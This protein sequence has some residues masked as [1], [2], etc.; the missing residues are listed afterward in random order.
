MCFVGVSGLTKN[1]FNQASVS[2]SNCPWP[3]PVPTTEAAEEPPPGRPNETIPD[4][5]EL[6][7]GL[8]EAPVAALPTTVLEPLMRKTGA[9]VP[10][11]MVS[12]ARLPLPPVA[13]ASDCGGRNLAL[14]LLSFSAF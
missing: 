3:S 7:G 9:T 10:V 6:R 14:R 4:A 1:F 12:D 2:A 11:S 13:A 5:A 8:G